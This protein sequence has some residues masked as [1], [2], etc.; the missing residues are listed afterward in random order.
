MKRPVAT[1]FATYREPLMNLPCCS[2]LSH[3]SPANSRASPASRPQI[4]RH[5]R[6]SALCDSRVVQR[7]RSRRRWL[8]G[9]AHAP[10]SSRPSTAPGW[11]RRTAPS[12]RGPMPQPR[13]QARDAAQTRG[14]GP[15][16]DRG[17]SERE[18]GRSGTPT[19]PSLDCHGVTIGLILPGRR[20]TGSRSG[21]ELQNLST[22]R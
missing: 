1:P 18:P 11:C 2:I 15:G 16:D 14:P 17:L 10:A 21:R 12:R 19:R 6:A 3:Q 20:G 8:P 9:G 22:L 5:R 4:N 7:R 13:T